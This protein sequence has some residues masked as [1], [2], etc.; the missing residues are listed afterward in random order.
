MDQIQQVRCA[1]ERPADVHGQDPIDTDNST[2]PEDGAQDISQ[3]PAV[4]YSDGV[5]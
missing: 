3:D 1:V 2:R 5:E 4:D